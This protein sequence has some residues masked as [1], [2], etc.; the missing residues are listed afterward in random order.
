M[1][2]PE[3]LLIFLPCSFFT[4]KYSLVGLDKISVLGTSL[5]PCTFY[6]E[7]ECMNNFAVAASRNYIFLRVNLSSSYYSLLDDYDLD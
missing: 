1:L 6:S 2:P 7:A 5:Q 3:I 4:S